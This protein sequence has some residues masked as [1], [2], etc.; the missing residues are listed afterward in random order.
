MTASAAAGGAAAIA[1]GGR[2]APPGD[3]RHNFNAAGAIL[4]IPEPE[5]VTDNERRPTP[6]VQHHLQQLRHRLHPQPLGNLQRP[7]LSNAAV[8]S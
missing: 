8:G 7:L 1:A 5:P 2:F 4:D 6:F 3:P